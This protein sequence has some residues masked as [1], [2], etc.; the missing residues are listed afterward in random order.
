MY[1]ELWLTLPSPY[2]KQLV[3]YSLIK[4]NVK[5]KCYKRLRT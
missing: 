5:Q 2:L 1:L 3:F 4:T